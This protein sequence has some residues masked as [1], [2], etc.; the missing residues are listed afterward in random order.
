MPYDGV[1]TPDANKFASFYLQQITRELSDDIDYVR[2]AED[3]KADSVP[4]LVHALRQGASQFLTKD[5]NPVAQG[6]RS[7]VSLNN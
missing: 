3:F 4:F 5:R 7:G 6:R 2:A 1:N